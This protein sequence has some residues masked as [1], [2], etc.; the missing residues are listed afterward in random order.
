MVNIKMHG[1]NVK[2]YEYCMQIFDRTLHP[3]QCALP[4]QKKDEENFSRH[5]LVFILQMGL[6]PTIPMFE[7]QTTHLETRCH[8]DLTYSQSLHI[9]ST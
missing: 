4:T 6:E 7:L 9:R 8:C 5:I 2:I 3:S 1:T